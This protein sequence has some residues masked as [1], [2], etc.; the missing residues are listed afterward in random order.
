M[1]E[2]QGRKALF[3]PMNL[4]KT[5]ISYKGAAKPWTRGLSWLVTIALTQGRAQ[6]T[7]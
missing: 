1:A 2:V 4:L 6:Q 3:L 5:V 7:K